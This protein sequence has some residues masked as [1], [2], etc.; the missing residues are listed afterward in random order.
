M[1]P[2]LPG[3]NSSDLMAYIYSF[4]IAGLV[5]KFMLQATYITSVLIAIISTAIT[6]IALYIVAAIFT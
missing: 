6:F 2:F 4:L 5:Y 3:A 1:V